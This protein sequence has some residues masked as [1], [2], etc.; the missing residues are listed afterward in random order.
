MR[1]AKSLEVKEM[2]KQLKAICTRLITDVFIAQYIS[3]AMLHFIN[4]G[5]DP[6]KNGKLLNNRFFQ[7]Y[8]WSVFVEAEIAPKLKQTSIACEK[9]LIIFADFCSGESK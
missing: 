7:A 1:S 5:M 4:A 9:W 8:I 2:E 6:L 3:T